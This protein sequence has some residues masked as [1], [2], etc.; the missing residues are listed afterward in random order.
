MS[1]AGA[2]PAH[3]HLGAILYGAS[4]QNAI[5]MEGPHS[6]F[7]AFATIDP[8]WAVVEYNAAD[9]SHPKD[10]PT[11]AAAYRGLRDM[12]NYGARFVSPMAWPGSDGRNAGKPGY[13]PFT[14]WRNTPLEDAAKDFLLARAHL[15]PGSKL[16]TF[17]APGHADADGWTA[18]A[19]S[20]A[21]EPG[22]AVVTP[23]ASGTVALV[24]PRELMLDR[25]R[26][27]RVVVLTDGPPPRSLRIQGRDAKDAP[28]SALAA[29]D[30]QEARLPATHGPPVD[31]LR[32]E[33][34]F[35]AAAPSAIVRVAI[36][37]EPDQA[38]AKR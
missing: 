29:A 34:G 3:G 35:G 31:G 8:Y 13:D 27:W 17:G 22:R 2:K 33:L 37:P 16:W 7:G 24:S 21:A 26:P 18:D 1:V 4:A 20:L 6:L 10:L 12:W 32:I 30:G 38:A 14:A 28:W 36:V 5:R 9:L 15:A 25:A 19:G 23:D 11:Y